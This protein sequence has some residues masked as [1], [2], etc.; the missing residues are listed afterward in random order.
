LSNA[1]FI[2]SVEHEFHRESLG[3]E[4]RDTDALAYRATFRGIPSTVSYQPPSVTP[5]PRVFGKESAVVTGPEEIHVDSFGRIKVYF[6]FDREDPVDE[7]ASCWLRVQQ[8]NTS[9]SMILPRRGWEV[10]VGF[11][12]GDPDRPIVLQKVYNAETMPPYG[13]PANKTQSALQSST[14]PGGGST[15]EIRLQDGNGGMDFFVHSS[16]DFHMV[17]GNDLHEDIAVDAHEDIGVSHTSTVVGSES[18]TI[19]AKQSVS[20]TGNCSA[21]TNGAKTVSIGANDD[22]GV[23]GNASVACDGSRTESVGGMMNVLAN[24]VSETFN[25]SCTKT[26]AAAMAIASATVIIDAAGGAKSELVGA[27]KLELLGK[28]KAEQIA[29]PKTLIAG[30][31]TEK[32]GADIGYTATGA[33][34]FQVGGSIAETCGGDFTCS[35]KAI[36]VTAPGGIN[37]K[38]GG[39]PYTLKGANITVD[40][41]TMG[42]TGSA[43]V[44]L[45]GKVKY[46]P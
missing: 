37:I 11:I 19:G 10:S 22:F 23:T 29:G 38:G 27:A 4:R 8:Q 20:V 33:V 45:D 15:N 28:A 2:L 7:T 24:S 31:M 9:G 17:A 30:F 36:L 12:A 35:A 18:V 1:Y 13:L 39:T 6:Y 26:V 43:T 34:G 32:T 3:G 40:A 42:I 44:K 14:S 25:D 21:S 5:K 46:K 16:K 41:G